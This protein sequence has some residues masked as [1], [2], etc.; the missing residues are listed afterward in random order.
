MVEVVIVTDITVVV[1]VVAVAIA[2]AVV[3]VLV[4]VIVVS[5]A[6]AKI[7]NYNSRITDRKMYTVPSTPVVPKPSYPFCN[8]MEL[9]IFKICISI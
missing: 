4:K 6:A 5:A 7:C 3:V 2:G 9:N 1:L 8:Y